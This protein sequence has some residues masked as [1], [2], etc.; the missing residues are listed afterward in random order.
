MWSGWM[1]PPDLNFFT[2][3]DLSWS[4]EFASAGVRLSRMNLAELAGEAGLG[5]ASGFAVR[6]GA[7]S[8]PL[9]SEPQLKRAF[10]AVRRI[11]G[12]LAD[13]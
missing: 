10:S 9:V 2:P 13:T 7:S 5:D 12:A 3:V 11:R 6:V 8:L 4:G 1:V